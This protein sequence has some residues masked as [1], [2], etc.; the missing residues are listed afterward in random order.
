MILYE[1]SF[2]ICD[3]FHQIYMYMDLLISKLNFPC[4][5]YYSNSNYEISNNSDVKCSYKLEIQ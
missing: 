1:L 2:I 3:P 4:E 5:V